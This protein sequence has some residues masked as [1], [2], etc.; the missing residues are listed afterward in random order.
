M[1]L[2]SRAVL[3]RVFPFLAWWPRVDR[4][5]LR[6][7]LIAGMAGATVKLPQGVAFGALAGMPPAD[8]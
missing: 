5:S 3:S 1:S 6:V 4:V 2:P 8:K 7:Y